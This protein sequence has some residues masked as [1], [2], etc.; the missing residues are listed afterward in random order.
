MGDPVFRG[1]LF[2]LSLYF[3]QI[4]SHYDLVNQLLLLG[5]DLRL[6]VFS[7][8]MLSNPKQLLLILFALRHDL[9]TTWPALLIDLKLG[10]IDAHVRIDQVR[11]VLVTNVGKIS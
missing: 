4:S 3:A 9:L 7:A 6:L 1:R 5:A 10:L 8:A 11:V 2:N